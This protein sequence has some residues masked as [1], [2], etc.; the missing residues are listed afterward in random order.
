MWISEL[1]LENWR[2]FTKVEVHLTPRV[3]LIGPNASGKSNFLEAIR[4]LR[5]LVIPGGGFQKAVSDRGGISKIRCLA[6]R[7]RTDIGIEVALSTDDRQTLPNWRYQISFNRDKNR[8]PVLK[9]EKVWREDTVILERPQPEDEDDPARLSQT[10]LEQINENKNFRE[11][12]DFFTT[13]FYFHLVPQLI[14]KPG[15][16]SPSPIPNDPFGSDFLERLGQTPEKMRRSRLNKIGSALKSAVPHLKN[17]EWKRDD[18]GAPHLSGKYQHWRP[19]GAEQNE[20]EFSDGTLRLIGLLWSLFEGEGPLLLEEPELSL[21]PAIVRHLAPLI[22]RLERTR[23]R[24]VRQVIISTH[25]PELLSDPGIG[26]E[27]TLLLIPQA[28]GTEVKPASSHH[29]IRALLES[30][31]TV[32]EAALPYTEPPKSKQLSLFR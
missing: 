16:F 8:N 1:K 5:E 19:R 14:R 27:E 4:F 20:A 26:G 30:G 6:A 25:S 10:A 28:G 22:Y 31:L 3:F 24:Q 17:L 23:K 9:K 32:N 7:R 2:N 29:A 15:Y 21:H 13:I 18:R 12:A 11:I